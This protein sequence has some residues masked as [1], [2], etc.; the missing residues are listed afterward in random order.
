MSINPL[1]PE[2]FSP[3]N[4]AMQPKIGYNR[5]PTHRRGAHMFFMLSGYFKI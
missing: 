3:L 1:L 2:L 5:L 4:F